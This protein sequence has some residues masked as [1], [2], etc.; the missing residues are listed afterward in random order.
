MEDSVLV[1][2][3]LSNTF[4]RRFD[5]GWSQINICL[6]HNSGQE[7]SRTWNELTALREQ[8]DTDQSNNRNLLFFG[9]T[10]SLAFINQEPV[11]R[12]FHGKNDGLRFPA[13]Q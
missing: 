1:D 10:T 3:F 2:W 11:R 8:H 5:Q 7:I 4:K 12:C 13:I 6:S 9:H